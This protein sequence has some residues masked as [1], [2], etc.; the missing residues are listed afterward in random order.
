MQY[1]L[2]GNYCS[3]NFSS[4]QNYILLTNRLGLRRWKDADTVPFAAMCRDSRVMEFFPKLLSAEESGQM[5]KRIHLHFET[6]GFGLYAVDKLSTG[7]FI[8]FTG[9]MIPAFTSFFTPCI[10]IGWRFHKEEWTKGYATEVATAC[11]EYGFNVLQF[12]R[13]YSFTSVKNVR[14]EKVMQKIGMRKAGEF[15]HPAIP[16]GHPL[17]QHVLY[18]INRQQ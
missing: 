17:C 18:E 14:S 16:A 15:N 11:L 12:N 8:G 10:E 1:H 9:F 2:T 3:F 6:H 13:V 5:I 7:S 4:L